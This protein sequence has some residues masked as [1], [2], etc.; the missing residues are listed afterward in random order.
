M[1]PQL[2]HDVTPRPSP[3]FRSHSRRVLAAGFVGSF[4]SVGFSVYLFGVFQS[5]MLGA[6]G[7]DVATFALA[8]VITSSVSGLFA[9]FVGRSLTTR[10]RAGWSVRVVMMGGAAAMGVGLLVVSR[11]PSL[12]WSGLFLALF[13]APGMVMLGPLATQAMVANWFD[14]TRGRALGIVAAGTTVAGGVVPVLAATLIEA[15]GWRDALAGLGVLLLVI[16]LPVIARFAVS[17]PE[18]VGEQVDGRERGDAASSD[19]AHSPDS[20]A[21]PLST[22]ALLR[23][24]Q[25][26]IIGVLFG[27]QFSA[28]T[29]AVA[30]TVP[31]A[32]QLGLGLVAGASVLGLR[33]WFGALG[34]ITLSWLSD[35]TGPRAVVFGALAIQAALTG[36][37]IQT[38]DPMA[39]ALFGVG[40]GFAGAA[41]L[42]LKG[43][44]L[45][46]VFGRESFGSVFGLVQLIALPFQLV[47]LPLAGFVYDTTSDWAN[48]FR[49]TIPMFLAAAVLLGFVAP[50]IRAGRD[51]A[52]PRVAG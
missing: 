5:E 24:P 38:R 41:M 9:P 31:Y 23:S 46:Q 12:A 32:Q 15:L 13:V 34:K 10:G 42:P 17:S 33:S 1:A 25:V 52:A 40:V 16:P 30:F 2:D 21:A 19:P 7:G 39:F 37:M 50:A 43:A 3:G 28:G 36:L 48:V 49:L 8:S 20:P 11:M 51:G 18:E 27:L 35:Y 22:G 6:F 47:T 14:A 44:L 4:F 29:L 45:A 26:W